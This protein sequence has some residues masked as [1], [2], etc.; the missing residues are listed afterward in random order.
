MKYSQETIYHFT[1]E[2]CSLWWSIATDGF[3]KD[4]P[5]HCPHCSHHHNPPHLD[6]NELILS[7]QL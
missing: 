5:L 2:K 6:Q 1:C 3:L 4:R 7:T